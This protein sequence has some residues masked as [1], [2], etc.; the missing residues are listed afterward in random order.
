MKRKIIGQISAFVRK[1]Y[2]LIIIY[3]LENYRGKLMHLFERAMAINLIIILCI[4]FQISPV[5]GVISGS[6]NPQI[7]CNLIGDLNC[8]GIVSMKEVRQL[9]VHLLKGEVSFEIVYEAIKNFRMTDN[10][11]DKSFD[12][13]DQ[14]LFD[15][16]IGDTD[17]GPFN[18]GS[19]D[20]GVLSKSKGMLYDENIQENR[21]KIVSSDPPLMGKI[22]DNIAPQTK[23]EEAYQG[24]FSALP[25]SNP[26][27][28]IA[29]IHYSPMGRNINLMPIYAEMMAFQQGY[30]PILNLNGNGYYFGRDF[31]LGIIN[32]NYGDAPFITQ[33]LADP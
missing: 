13:N 33:F 21:S 10:N 31:S 8:D 11:R 19:T 12:S 16:S 29:A 22:L 28:S 17:W 27:S 32:S 23:T 18:Q 9:N 7:D 1:T 15:E 2:K 14:R 6:N 5:C 3:E 30:N 24:Y 20:Y 25:L 4:S 26:S